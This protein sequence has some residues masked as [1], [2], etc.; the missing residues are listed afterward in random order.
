MWFK[1]LKVKENATREEVEAAYRKLSNEPS[2]VADMEKGMEL[3]KAYSEAM[4]QFTDLS[5]YAT[6][7]YQSVEESEVSVTNLET[8]KSVGQ[9]AGEKLES[10]KNSKGE[11]VFTIDKSLLEE[12]KRQKT[13][14]NLD[15]RTVIR[16]LRFVVVLGVI[17][18]TWLS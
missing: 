14:N 1:V 15:A 17:I 11:Q 7:S 18:Y 12:N 4:E 2:V 9:S 8:E 13:A 5:G 6:T 10:L 16:I 3:R